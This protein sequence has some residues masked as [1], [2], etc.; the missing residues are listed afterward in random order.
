[1]TVADGEKLP[2]DTVG[3]LRDHL[4]IP[5]TTPRKVVEEPRFDTTESAK[6]LKTQLQNALERCK[7]LEVR[8]TALKA[9]T[10]K[11]P[12]SELSL[13]DEIAGALMTA[14]EA[15]HPLQSMTLDPTGRHNADTTATPI[16]GVATAAA[17]RHAK[18][19]RDSLYKALDV[20]ENAKTHDWH[21]PVK[22]PEAP[23]TRCGHRSCAMY[24]RRVPVWDEKGRALEF[25][26]GCGSRLPAPKENAA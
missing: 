18:K 12:T 10:P 15:S 5:R 13:L 7:G 24:D 21:P 9:L 1:M 3:Q 8:V 14:H 4:G 16:P 11:L 26:S 19:L 17:R 25:C 2:F 20:F 22:N 6:A 23:K